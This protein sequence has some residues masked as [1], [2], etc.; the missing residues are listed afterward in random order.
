I[1][2]LGM[3]TAALWSAP[4]A[5]GSLTV[6]DLARDCSMTSPSSAVQ[7]DACSNYI[8]GFVDGAIATDER[9]AFNVAHEVAQGESYSERAYRT[10]L[11]RQLDRFGPSYYAGICLGNPVPIGEAIQ[12]IRNS[13][14]AA[15]NPDELAAEFV[16]RVLTEKFPC[17]QLQANP[18]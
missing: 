7:T 17:E 11:G 10:R 12:H 2:V 9:V 4:L 8:R 1:C 15:G 5:A 6:A 16:Y 3:L 14:D 18:R 13:L